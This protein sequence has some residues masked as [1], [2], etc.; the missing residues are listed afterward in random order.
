MK[1][2]V[3]RKEFVDIVRALLASGQMSIDDKAR[4]N[5]KK[6]YIS[7]K[8]NSVILNG[9]DESSI[10]YNRAT[11]PCSES[12]DGVTV[13]TDMDEFIDNL[14]V[15][16]DVNVTVDIDVS[17]YKISDVKQSIEGSLSTC[18]VPKDLL[19][20][21]E[22]HGYRNGK[23]GQISA[24]RGNTVFTKWFSVPDG[25]VFSNLEYIALKKIVSN[26]WVI[27]TNDDIRFTCENKGMSKMYSYKFEGTAF[28]KNLLSIEWLHPV[29]SNL[30]GETEF[31][32]YITSNGN[33]QLWIHNN[34]ID[35]L[36]RH[37]VRKKK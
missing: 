25:N 8:E 14:K 37:D 23:P 19:F 35:W 33:V 12:E 18:K 6:C 16:K 13:I 34:H 30:S 15:F 26:N 1:F 2:T 22:S 32:L 17:G 10:I 4:S 7:V 9:V 21:S 29:L 5:V 36:T 24:D 31:W 27:D 3:L 28:S 20:F 11:I